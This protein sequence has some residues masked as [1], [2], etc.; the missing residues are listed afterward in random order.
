MPQCKELEGLPAGPVMKTALPVQGVWV[1]SLIG[2]LRSCMLPGMARKYLIK[3][4]EM[5]WS[6]SSGNVVV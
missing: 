4:T 5:G 3:K 6:F 2:E 1:P